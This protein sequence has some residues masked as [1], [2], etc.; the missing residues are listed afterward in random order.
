MSQ[1]DDELVNH[2][3]SI[4]PLTDRQ[5]Y[6]KEY[7][8]RPDVIERRRTRENRLHAARKDERKQAEKDYQ[9]AYRERQKKLKGLGIVK[10]K[11]VNE[12]DV[13]LLKKCGK[14]FKICSE[15]CEKANCKFPV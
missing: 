6:Q 8:S 5:I 3:I 9:A 13:P 15:P 4:P 10:P 11:R 1:L 2:P 12:R 7:H 14:C